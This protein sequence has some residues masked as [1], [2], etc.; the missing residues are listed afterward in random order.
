MKEMCNKRLS[1]FRHGADGLLSEG[2]L[3]VPLRHLLVLIV[4]DGSGEVE[5]DGIGYGLRRCSVLSLHHGYRVCL[6]AVSADFAVVG[7]DVDMDFLMDFPLLMQIGIDGF[8]GNSPCSL[9]GNADQELILRYFDLLADR[10]ASAE[11]GEEV[12]KGLLF[13]MLMELCR[14]CYAH[15]VSLRPTRKN[16]LVDK[17]FVLLGKNFTKE[18]TALFYARQLCV[19]DKHLM[20][21]IKEVSGRS[22]HFWI[23]DVL[24]RE[25]KLMLRS[26]DMTVVQVSDRLGFPNS[27]SFAR[28]FR[29]LAGMSPTE[30][31]VEN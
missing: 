30:Y 2:E 20:R 13:A 18:R 12:L 27:S 31:R 15:E 21:V 26:S 8:M 24:L 1:V 3:Q 29:N 19:S 23:S 4:T 5:I 10:C 22:F 6:R 28:F 17:F 7:V 25:A 9:L 11:A 14:M 16:E